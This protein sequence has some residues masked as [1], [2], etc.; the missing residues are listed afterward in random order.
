MVSD[1][2]PGWELAPTAP[3]YGL[4]APAAQRA[5]LAA[6]TRLV[7]AA[8]TALQWWH[9]PALSPAAADGF[10]AQL[11]AVARPRRTWL[12]CD[13]A[14]AARLAAVPT[15][16]LRRSTELPAGAEPEPRAE[17]R[18][19]LELDGGRR[20]AVAL[21]TRWPPRL[22]GDWLAELTADP[23]VL[24]TAVHLQPVPAARA[25]RLLRHRLT[26]LLS[27]RAVGECTGQP[28]DPELVAASGAAEALSMQLAAG[29]TAVLRT[30]VLFVV[31]GCDAAE[32]AEGLGRLRRTAAALL[33]TVSVA[34]FEQSPA[35]RAAQPGGSALSRP[36]RLLTAEAVAATVPH[37]AGTAGR[38]GQGLLAGI[39]PATGAPL[40]LARFGLGNPTRLVVGTSGAGK[41]FAAKLEAIRWHDRGGDVV[42]VDPEGEFGPVVRALGGAVLQAGTAGG[43]G[44]VG[45]AADPAVHPGEALTLLASVATALSAEPLTAADLALLDRAL[46]QL[47]QRPDGAEIPGPDEL[48][49]AIAAGARRRPFTQ[50]TLPA[51]LTPLA[52]GTLAALFAGNPLLA[53]PPRALAVDLRDVP[54]RARAAATACLLGWAWIWAR[55]QARPRLLVVDE[56]H[57][58]LDDRASAELLAGFARRCRKYRTALEVLT[59]RLSD[60]L[61]CPPGQALL[62]NAATVLVLGCA[63]AERDVVAAGLHLSAAEADLLRP[64]VPGRGLLLCGGDHHPLQVVAS[65]AE[66][67]L[68]AS[69][70]RP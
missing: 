8:E 44:P 63:E 52:G 20:A 25:L 46:T 16:P 43:L 47:R 39:D 4:A 2:S 19:Y 45:V 23:A 53:Q 69:G 10:T 32:L 64:G 24:A 5:Q 54:L 3:G 34:H 48:C 21:L 60:F 68:A 65:P 37:P 11:A 35:W 22:V 51:R 9:A 50:S 41:S 14:Q 17:H 58:L 38:S 7:G 28:P 49:A 15:A 59:Q 70:P 26:G 57:L 55:G 12:V 6:L 30:Q 31:T 66:A 40:T 29:E 56:A 62:A 42:I 18:S 33:A 61:D 67:A 13:P 27:S 36:W 1:L